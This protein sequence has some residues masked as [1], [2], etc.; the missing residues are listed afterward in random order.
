MK[1]AKGQHGCCQ[2]KAAA[3]NETTPPPFMD[4]RQPPPCRME[5]E[6]QMKGL[7]KSTSKQGGL[8]CKGSKGYAF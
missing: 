3:D 6:M 8:G 7:Q 1:V 2:I 4:K 5:E